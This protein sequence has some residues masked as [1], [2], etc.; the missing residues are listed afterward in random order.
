MRD[1]IGIDFLRRVIRRTHVVRI[2]LEVEISGRRLE[3]Q[4]SAL[5]DLRSGRRRI[6]SDQVVFVEM[7]GKF[8]IGPLVLDELAD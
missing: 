5:P 7:P 2:H 1:A 4:S 8:S 3:Q 6:H